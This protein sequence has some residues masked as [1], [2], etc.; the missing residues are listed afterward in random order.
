M[1]FWIMYSLHASVTHC[2]C[3]VPTVATKVTG[4]NRVRLQSGHHG[5]GLSS[6]VASV[7]V[8]RPSMCGLKSRT[9]VYVSA[10]G[11]MAAR[12]RVHSGEKVTGCAAQACGDHSIPYRQKACFASG[13]GSLTFYRLACRIAVF[14]YR[15]LRRV[16]PPR[17][18]AALPERAA[19]AFS[20]A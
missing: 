13:V 3:A 8:L 12:Q 4:G 16:A 9:P 14:A 17:L 15:L 2:W 6:I 19:G 11:N 1:G 7:M 20:A 5:R 18:R 10:C